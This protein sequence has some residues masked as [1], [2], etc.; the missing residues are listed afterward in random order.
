MWSRVVPKM[1]HRGTIDLTMVFSNA[2]WYRIKNDVVETARAI[3]YT[4]ELKRALFIA[5]P[6]RKER[7]TN[8][9]E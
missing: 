8:I 6:S 9:K 3:G 2:W 5:F 7:T 1:K 4:L